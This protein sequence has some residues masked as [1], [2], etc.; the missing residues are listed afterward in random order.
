MG[1]F[2]FPKIKYN[3]KYAFLN[4]TSPRCIM[5]KRGLPTPPLLPEKSLLWAPLNLKSN[6]TWWW[7]QG[8]GTRNIF[9]G[10]RNKQM[11]KKIGKKSTA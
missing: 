5:P 4:Y 8:P 10:F 9:H 7:S 1:F 6:H 2:N 11:P 3:V